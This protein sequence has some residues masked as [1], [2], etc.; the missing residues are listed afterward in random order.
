MA[1]KRESTSLQSADDYTGTSKK[2][3]LQRSPEKSVSSIS[4][5][6]CPSHSEETDKV[7]NL[8]DNS[9]SSD[10]TLICPQRSGKRDNADYLND[11]F[12]DI[13]SSIADSPQKS[14]MKSPKS[15][16]VLVLTFVLHKFNG[17]VVAISAHGNGTY[18][19]HKWFQ[20]KTPICGV[21]NT[22]SKGIFLSDVSHSRNC[23]RYNFKGV[24]SL[25]P[26]AGTWYLVAARDDKDMFLESAASLERLYML[27]EP[28][29]VGLK[30]LET[31]DDVQFNVNTVEEEVSRD[32]FHEFAFVFYNTLKSLA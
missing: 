7:N 20:G 5:L 25:K 32:L 13:K 2:G 27:L 10:S 18:H 4:S 24:Q 12:K 28:H 29:F 23:L 9:V 19:I 6:F 1:S 21:E 17:H 30:S 31:P 11:L 8:M 14:P 26:G 22:F 15:P 16:K 3:K